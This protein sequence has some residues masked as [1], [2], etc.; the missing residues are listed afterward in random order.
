MP[1]GI[2]RAVALLGGQAE[3]ARQLGL[4]RPTVNEWVKGGR[5]IPPRH[6]VSIERLTG[7]KVT[8]RQ[9]HAKWAE[10]WPELVI[11]K[12]VA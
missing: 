10:I 4:S 11:R 1:N 9:L 2:E 5:P 12:A 7:G 6:C 8:R 3:L